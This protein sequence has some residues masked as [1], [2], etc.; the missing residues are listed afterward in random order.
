MDRFKN[1]T[2]N[3]LRLFFLA[4][5]FTLM[6]S[7][8]LYNNYTIYDQLIKRSS[9]S[10]LIK[11]AL[12]FSDYI[13]N[14]FDL[15]KSLSKKALNDDEIISIEMSGSDVKELNN[16]LEGLN[17]KIFINDKEKK[18]RKAKLLL[19]NSKEKIKYKIHGTSTTPFKKEEF[20]L[21]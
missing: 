20:H 3:K 10:F 8:Y 16:T 11:N 18:W 14:Q 6:L 17:D 19:G 9:K 21:E 2:F 12:T 5:L 1:K 15:I 4:T 13:F 7:V